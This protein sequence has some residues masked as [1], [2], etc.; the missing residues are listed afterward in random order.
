MVW[1]CSR[2]CAPRNPPLRSRIRR[3]GRGWGRSAGG[4]DTR[5]LHLPDQELR[6]G[7]YGGVRGF[8]HQG[9]RRCD[10]GYAEPVAA[11]VGAPVVSTPGPCTC[12]TKSYA[13]DGMV[14]FADL[15]TKESAAAISDTPSRSRLGS[16]RRWCRHPGLAPA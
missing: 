12:L 14:V 9:I 8:V 10:L 11:G 5:A 13:Q 1:W 6:A 4:V 7:W 2:I 16:E 3:A 15:C